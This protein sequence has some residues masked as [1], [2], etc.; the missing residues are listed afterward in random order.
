MNT[1]LKQSVW[2]LGWVTAILVQFTLPAAADSTADLILSL[3]CP[4][5]YTVNV[6]QRYGSQELLY[7]GSGPLGQLNLGKGTRDRTGA[8]QVYKFKQG[9]YDYQAIGGTQEHQGRGTLA[10]FKKG[11]AILNLVCTE[12]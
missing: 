11:R 5:E 12:S 2:L 10:V 7:R 1:R 9:D 8:A 3:Q 6:W 4:G